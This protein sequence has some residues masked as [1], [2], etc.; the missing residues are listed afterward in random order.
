MVS[1]VKDHKVLTQLFDLPNIDDNV[2]MNQTKINVHTQNKSYE[3]P[4]VMLRPVDIVHETDQI[5][6][7]EQVGQT[8][9]VEQV[10][11]AGHA[12]QVGHVEQA[13]QPHPIYSIRPM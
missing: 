5:Y 2:F 13:E 3:Q 6:S 11:H 9:Q 12:E 8:G 4:I 1:F 7:A 10:G